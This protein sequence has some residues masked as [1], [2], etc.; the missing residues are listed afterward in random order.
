MTFTPDDLELAKG[1]M[2]L[3]RASLD[4]LGSQLSANHYLIRRDYE[5]VLRHKNRLLKDEASPALLESI[6]E[7]VVTCG[8]Q[9]AAYRSALF[10]KLARSMADYYG[11]ITEGREQLR[12]CYVPSWK[13]HDPAVVV[14]HTFGRDEAREELSRALMEKRTAEL[15]RRRA[16][17]GPHADKIEFFIDGKN[18]SSYGSQGQQRSVVLAF[19]LAEAS[20]IQDILN[21]KPVLLLD[22]V[23]SEL[24]ESRRRAL[25]AFIAG[26]IQTFITTANIDYFDADLLS[27]AR[28]VSLPREGASG[29]GEASS[30]NRRPDAARGPAP[31]EG[32]AT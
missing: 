30:E 11:E 7:M 27:S 28:V 26:D 29:S 17:V 23:M 16:L 32:E 31:E 21:Q 9:L 19:K 12:A 18:A 22:D 2:S 8:A 4:A 6:D 25:V 14:T 13:A 5:K 3:R 10:E 24:D 1:S 15:G 20:L